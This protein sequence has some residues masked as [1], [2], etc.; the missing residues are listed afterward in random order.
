L[1]GRRIAGSGVP[2]GLFLVE[3]LYDSLIMLLNDVLRNTLH[4]E[5]LNV[6]TLSIWERIFDGR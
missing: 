3:V 5:D 6:E 1:S 2:L 4:A